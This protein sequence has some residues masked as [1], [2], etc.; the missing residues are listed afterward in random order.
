MKLVRFGP[1]DTERPGI[2]DNNGQ[3]RDAQSLVDDWHG[4]TLTDE[5]LAQVAA[6]AATLPLVTDNPHPRLGAPVGTISKFIVIGLNYAAHAAEAGLSPP[7]DPIIVLAS[8]T[9][10]CGGNDTICLPPNSHKTD[11]EIELGVVIGRG[12]RFIAA[13]E[14]LQH[15]AGYCIANDV[16]ERE[17]QI[18]RGTQWGKGKSYDTFKPL[19]PWL[20][21]RDE[22]PDPQNLNMQLQR[23]GKICQQSNTQDMIF[24][25]AELISRISEYMTL[26]AGDVLV[27]GTPPGVGYGMKP[28]QFLCA[29]D[30]LQLNIDG[31]GQQTNTVAA[32]VTHK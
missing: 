5:C 32:H 23:N 26:C 8:P 20:V 7:T 18:E 29:G 1:P 24:P 16:S 31:L 30:Q 19:G 15:V 13:T 28:P 3:L 12:G 25:V 27:T 22:I 4:A 17:Y 2:I 9:A 11:W 21:T 14:A 10:V 6:A